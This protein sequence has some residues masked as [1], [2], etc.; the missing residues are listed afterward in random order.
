[1]RAPTTP[2]QIAKRAGVILA[3][4]DG[5]SVRSMAERVG[6]SQ[7]TVCQWRGRFLSEG[8]AGLHTRHRSG[9]PRRITTADEARIVAAAMRPLK[10]ATH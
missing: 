5:V 3:S 8:I 7:M 4:A 9:R 2:Q 10:A 6:I 1:M